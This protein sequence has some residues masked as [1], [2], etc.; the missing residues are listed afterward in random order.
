MV[1][2]KPQ[3]TPT[4]FIIRVSSRFQDVV[5]SETFHSSICN[6]THDHCNAGTLDHLR[7]WAGP[8]PCVLISGAPDLPLWTWRAPDRAGSR[9]A[10]IPQWLT[11][12]QRN[13][14][15]ATPTPDCV[16]QDPRA[17][18]SPSLTGPACSPP[19]KPQGPR[20]PGA[21][22]VRHRNRPGRTGGWRALS[23]PPIPHLASRA[24]VQELAQLAT[25]RLAQHVQVHSSVGQ[26]RRHL[27]PPLSF[28]GEHPD[29]VTWQQHHV[30]RATDSTQTRKL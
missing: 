30:T 13:K 29:A 18:P 19:R 15:Y 17:G 6:D 14:C 7:P 28:P 24:L 20:T 11:V 25:H 5:A 12:Q 27:A 1:T 26:V 9:G 23:P 3:I 4:S 22:A 10:E 21:Q 16:P 8:A 2:V